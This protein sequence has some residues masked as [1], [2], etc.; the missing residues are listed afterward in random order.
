[1]D[2]LKHQ[3]DAENDAFPD[4]SSIVLDGMAAFDTFLHR[5]KRLEAVLLT[6]SG[7]PTEHPLGIVTVHDIPRMRRTLNE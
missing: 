1:M 7:R 4:R 6:Q 3:E 2:D 5:G